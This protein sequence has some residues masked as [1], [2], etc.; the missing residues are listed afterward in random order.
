VIRGSLTSNLKRTGKTAETDFA[1]VLTVAMGGGLVDAP[2]GWLV[3]RKPNTCPTYLPA[4][5]VNAGMAACAIAEDKKV[6]RTR[7]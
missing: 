6:G 3:G 4:S 2:G 1:I 5:A 7:R